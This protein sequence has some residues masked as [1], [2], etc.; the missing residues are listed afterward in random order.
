MLLLILCFFEKEHNARPKPC[1]FRAGRNV[2]Y[3][4]KSLIIVSLIHIVYEWPA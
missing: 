4:Y 1:Q 2:I 3:V